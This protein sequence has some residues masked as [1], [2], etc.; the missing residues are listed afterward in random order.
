MNDL[1]KFADRV[2]E[3]IGTSETRERMYYLLTN[4]DKDYSN[5]MMMFINEFLA[6]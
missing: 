4:L 1:N 5:N 3:K 6:G 2:Y